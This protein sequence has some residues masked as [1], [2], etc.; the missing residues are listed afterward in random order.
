MLFINICNQSLETSMPLLRWH[1]EPMFGWPRIRDWGS[2]A[3]AAASRMGGGYRRSVGRTA[4]FICWG[5][6]GR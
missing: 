2:S 5:C 4:L 3:A 1:P 6:P